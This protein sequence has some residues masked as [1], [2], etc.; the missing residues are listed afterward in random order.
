MLSAKVLVSVAG[1]ATLSAV[2]V[3]AASPERAAPRA[4]DGKPDL[5]GIWNKRL[6]MNIAQGIEP[7]PFTP[8]GLKAFNDVWSRVDPTSECL[9]PGVPRVMDEPH[10]FQIV[11]LPD[12]V[13]VLYEYMHNFRVVPTD[14]RP[15]AKDKDEDPALMGHS[16]G[17]WENDTLIVDAVGFTDRTYLDPHGNRH[18]D[19]LHVIE[20]FSRPDYDTLDYQ[21]T[22]DDPKFYTRPWTVGWTIPLAPADWQL[23]EYDCT[24]NNKDFVEGHLG[25]GPLDGSPR[26]GSAIAPP[27]PQR[28]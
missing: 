12:K 26:D 21:V 10:P 22:I 19:A 25:L 6:H 8:A 3:S 9:F 20:R 28:K 18:S 15:H 7:L 4:S 23:M 14:G 1:A 13:I 5:S 2:L 17:R 11:Q 16:V 24:E 27:R